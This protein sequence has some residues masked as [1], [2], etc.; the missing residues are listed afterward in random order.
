LQQALGMPAV[1]IVLASLAFASIHQPWTLQPPV[2]V[3][4][5]VLGWAYFRSG[6]IVVP[7]V[8]HAVFNATQF[9]LFA[10]TSGN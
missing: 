4:S 8:A 5:L 6:S 1:A 2:F 7:M 3:L 10:A 9:G